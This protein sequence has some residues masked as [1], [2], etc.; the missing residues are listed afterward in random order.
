MEIHVAGG[1]YRERCVRPRWNEI[2]GSA[3]RAALAIAAMGTPAVLHAFMD[4]EAKEVIND[5]GHWLS[6]FRS[7]ISPVQGGVGFR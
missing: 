3:G 7:E 2:Y 1:V 6:C 4:A 5:K